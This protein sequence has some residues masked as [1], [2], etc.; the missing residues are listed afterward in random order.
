[1][2]STIIAAACVLLGGF[3]ACNSTE[4]QE[5][6]VDTSAVGSV[7]E[8]EAP[9]GFNFSEAHPIDSTDYV[10]YPLSATT[11]A[12]EEDEYGGLYKSSDRSSTYLN[13]VFYNM[14]SK[15]YRLLD[16][17]R[18][19]IKSYSIGD[20]AEEYKAKSSHGA[21]P[22]LIYYKVIVNDYNGDGKLGW[23]DP[24]YLFIS[25]LAGSYFKQ[26][27]PDNLNVDGWKQ[28][29]EKGKVLIQ[30]TEDTNRDKKFEYEGNSIPYVYDIKLGVVATPIFRKGFTDTVS[31]LLKKQWAKKEN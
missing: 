7:K 27:S 26:I 3:T 25:D 29:P 20:D 4:S 6:R 31:S 5:S 9:T 16:N 24:E 18:M 10:I 22:R 17:R 30:I 12:E 2:R 11:N 13:I 23:P 19:L 1:M 8:H 21:L 28:V 15:K 14:V